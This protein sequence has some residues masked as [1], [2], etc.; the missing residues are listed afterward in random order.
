[1][2]KVIA[3]THHK[4]GVGKTTSV[5][6]VGSIMA[7]KGYK[8]LLLD[9]DA[10]ANL[11]TIFVG[12]ERP[13]R[14][15]YNALSEG[16]KLPILQVKEKLYLA[17]SSLDMIGAETILRDEAQGVRVLSKLLD[18]VRSDFDFVLLDCPPSLGLVTIGALIAADSRFIV[19]PPEFIPFTGLNEFMETLQSLNAHLGEALT[20]DGV[21]VTRYTQRKT[22]QRTILKVLQSQYK[23]KVFKAVIRE[24]TKVAESPIDATDVA[25][26][27]PSSSGASDY[28]ALTEEILQRLSK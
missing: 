10:Q 6:N 2:G 28:A 11:T 5:L 19:L 1:M 12:S 26:Y 7:K 4:G 24:N 3:F 17:P 22:A 27:A 9:L 20:I 25:S 23:D 18:A 14:T 21:I 16:G 13:Q 8:T 15:I